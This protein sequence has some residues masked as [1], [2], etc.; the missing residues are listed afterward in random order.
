MSFLSLSA[1]LA[2]HLFQQVSFILHW[3]DQSILFRKLAIQAFNFTHAY[4]YSAAAVN[5]A[6]EADREL[7][8]EEKITLYRRRGFGIPFTRLIFVIA[9]QPEDIELLLGI[10]SLGENRDRFQVLKHGSVLPRTVI[11]VSED[12][13][14]CLR[15]ASCVHDVGAVTRG[16]AQ[17]MLRTTGIIASQQRSNDPEATIPL[18]E[19]VAGEGVFLV[20]GRVWNYELIGHILS[21]F[22][23]AL[24]INL[25][26]DPVDSLLARWWNYQPATAASLTFSSFPIEPLT[27]EDIV[28]HY[29]TYLQY[30]HKYSTLSRGSM[31]NLVYDDLVRSPLEATAEVLRRLSRLTQKVSTSSSV[32]GDTSWSSLSP[33]LQRQILELTDQF[34]GCSATSSVHDSALWQQLYHLP[35]VAELRRLYLTAVYPQLKKIKISS[36]SNRVNWKAALDYSY[37]RHQIRVK[38]ALIAPT[39]SKGM[40]G[41]DMRPGPDLPILKYLVT[42]LA[43]TLSDEWTW[44][45]VTLY[46][47]YDKGDALF[48]RLETRRVINET[49][50]QLVPNMRCVFQKLVGLGNRVV[51]IWNEM[52]RRAYDQGTDYFFLLGDDVVM[53]NRKWMHSM[54]ERLRDNHLLPNFG[55][56]AFYDR[57]RFS[58]PGTL[59]TF[60]VFHKLHLEIMGPEKAFDPFFVNQFADPWL[61]DIYQPFNSSGI[62]ADAQLFNVI[63]GDAMPRYA[64]HKTNLEQ[65]VEV[66]ERGRKTIAQYLARVGVPFPWTPQSLSYGPG[67]MHFNDYCL[68]SPGCQVNEQEN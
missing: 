41:E 14:Q 26:R 15:N 28:H 34:A 44:A 66:V 8:P 12:I 3:Y 58:T 51:H 19:D 65:F 18:Q 37:S 62:N 39:T 46:V 5:R 68:S 20:D 67:G 24:V 2:S 40:R 56:V 1:L 48:D 22:P 32:P 7:C 49:V 55:T 63:G 17:A 59:A 21:L 64:I 6:L 23:G 47:G 30:I 27:F 16:H 31:L 10:F 53:Q 11:S 42:G 50:R 13:G 38:V 61:Y 60:P 57:H 9:F 4:S 29:Q 25:L 52:A 35:E 45:D 54:V 33:S 36:V 43:E